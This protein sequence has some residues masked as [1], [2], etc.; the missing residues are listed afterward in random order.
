MVYLFIYS[1][2]SKMTIVIVIFTG[3]NTVTGELYE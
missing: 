1:I 3:T 2:I